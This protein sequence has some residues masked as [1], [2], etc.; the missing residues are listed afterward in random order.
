LAEIQQHEK[1]GED[2]KDPKDPAEQVLL[3]LL[4]HPWDLVDAR[5]LMRRF[6]ASAADV[7]RALG[8]FELYVPESAE[9]PAC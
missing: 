8:K 6:H 4:R 3:H 2:P 7:S 1:Q 9:E 5:R